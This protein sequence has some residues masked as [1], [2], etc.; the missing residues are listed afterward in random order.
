MVICFTGPYTCTSPTTKVRKYFFAA[1][2]YFF[3]RHDQRYVYVIKPFDLGPNFLFLNVIYPALY[4]NAC[5]S[6]CLPFFFWVW[7]KESDLERRLRFSY[8]TN[9]DIPSSGWARLKFP[10]WAFFFRFEFE[11]FQKTLDLYFYK[12]QVIEEFLAPFRDA[13]SAII[14]PLAF[15]WQRLK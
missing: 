8:D 4:L 3:K 15:D 5:W 9:S 6:H 7:K 11:L 12:N 10:V 1:F 2:L 14:L 13:S